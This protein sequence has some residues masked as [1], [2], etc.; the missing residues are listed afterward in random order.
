MTEHFDALNASDKIRDAYRDYLLTSNDFADA[1]VRE[2]F[3]RVLE[4]RFP[5]TKGPF[6]QA[7]PP[8]KKS[9]SLNELARDGVL[10]AEIVS[11]P[12]IIPNSD[13]PLYD[14]QVSAIKKISAG[15]NVVVATGTGSGKTEA[16]LLPIINSLLEERR[17]GTLSKPGVRAL[18]LYPMNAL[19]NDQLDR[20]RE[21]LANLPDITFGRYT[22]EVGNEDESSQVENYQRRYG[23]DPIPNEMLSRERMRDTPPHILLS[24]FTMLEYLLIRPVD[25]NFFDGDT[26]NHWRFIV[27]DEVH[28]YQG[29]KGGEIRMLLK[30]LRDRVVTSARDRITYIGTSATIGSLESDMPKLAEY[31]SLLFDETVEYSKS[32]DRCDIIRPQFEKQREYPVDVNL[33]ADQIADLHEAVVN[34]DP[35]ALTDLLDFHLAERGAHLSLPKRLG[36]LLARESTFQIILQSLKERPRPIDEIIKSFSGSETPR[37]TASQLI[38]LA[39]YAEAPGDSS[40]LLSARYHLLLRAL[41][42]M[43]YCY[44]QSHPE[45]QPRMSLEPHEHCR[46]CSQEEPSVMFEIGPCVQCGSTYLIGKV[47]NT[48]EGPRLGIAAPLGTDNVYLTLFDESNERDLEGDEDDDAFAVEAGIAGDSHDVR[49][50]CMKCGALDEGT[51]TCDHGNARR[52]VIHSKPKDSESPMRK[53]VVCSYQTR[54]NAIN[55]VQT[56]QDAPNSILA[57]AIYQQLPEAPDMSEAVGGGR[58]LL[59]FSDSRQDAAFFAPY[60]ERTYMRNVQRRLLL[61]ALREAD[62]VLR[63]EDLVGT[64]AR[65]SQRFH[66]L[67]DI[68]SDSSPEVEVR[69]WM[70]REALNLEG[71]LSLIG[72]GLIRIDSR[73]PAASIPT[74]LVESG[75]NPVESLHVLQVLLQIMREKGAID[76]PPTIDISDPIFAPRN[77]VS[78]MRKTSD[79]RILGWSP[80]AKRTNSRLDYLSRLQNEPEVSNKTRELLEAI[81]DEITPRTSAWHHLFKVDT[82]GNVP[83]LCLDY[84]MLD[85]SAT[86]V[87]EDVYECDTCRRVSLRNV[88]DICPQYRCT[89]RLR[90]GESKTG[91]RGQYEKLY[92][93]QLR[94]GMNVEEHTGQLSNTRASDVQQK[95]VE[96]YINTLSCSTTFEL[97]VDLGEIRAVLMKNVPP[98]AANYAQRAGRAGRRTSSTALVTTF[99]Q[100]RNHDLFYFAHPEEL[101]R[102]VVQAPQISIT[103]TLIIRRHIHSVALSAF[104]RQV[105]EEGGEWPRELNVGEFFYDKD[106]AGQT[107]AARFESWLRTHPQQLG[108][109]LKRIVDDQSTSSELGIQNWL[110][111]D[112]LYTDTNLN[113]KGWMRKAEIVIREHLADIDAL[114]REKEAEGRQLPT[115]SQKALA[116]ANTLRILQ[117]QANTIRGRKLIDYL[118]QRIVLPK[119]GFPVDVVSLDILSPNSTAGADIDLS[120]DLQMGILEF[121]PG[122][123]TVANKLLWEGNGLRIPPDKVLPEF[124]WRVCAK[125]GTFRTVNELDVGCDVCGSIESTPSV[126]AIIPSF[127]FLGKP[128][129]QKPG[130]SRPSRVG[131]LRSF[132]TEFTGQMPELEHVPIGKESV[133]VRVGKEA[134]VTVLNRGP[135]NAGFQICLTCGGAQPPSRSVRK[136][137]NN[138]PEKPHKRPGIRATEC[139]HRQ[140]R[141]VLG[142]QFRTDA[143]QIDLPG[144][145]TYEQGES[146]L[147]ALLAATEKL[148]IP[149]DDLKGTSRASRGGGSRSIVIYD[150]VP[151]GAG[152]SRAVREALD[153]LFSEAAAITRNCTCGEETSCYGCL[154]SY[155]NQHIHQELSRRR[156]NEVF[157]SLG[158]DTRI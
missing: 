122:S 57:S 63:F 81:W 61:D 119:Y 6:V 85:F 53:C 104:A 146:V 120:R 128:S 97:G 134:V 109:S 49:T 27:L 19:A 72:T 46:S 75:F 9:M 108:E 110:W 94:I 64:I 58:K 70:L 96:G 155:A 91:R 38:Y 133:G 39:K 145:V 34:N 156:A 18:L 50:L 144:L 20:L 17:A 150:A 121:A 78:R 148:D 124:D 130:D 152:Y 143:I 73:I 16:F 92:S 65:Q 51:P 13:R 28:T 112:D 151:G 82:K 11:H 45:S 59:C 142:H 101:V 26:G 29:A 125:C 147:A 44:A 132:F 23:K 129:N 88:R 141:R 14:H 55:R 48:D 158:L 47:N 56:G 105:V 103:N 52:K 15:R 77:F 83:S 84:K 35:A 4:Q 41:E 24:N 113:E 33:T 138:Q 71:R 154:R 5:L 69:K 66:V 136:R 22:G 98:T 126:K 43:F 79:G 86:N 114:I 62:E 32:D 42:G 117:K 67:S 137:T 111:V 36:D 139:T 21:L 54:G 93:Q 31:A 1:S 153:K 106:T 25:T 87:E 102:G 157:A 68:S 89:G 123:T 80:K 107:M 100:R 115:G 8:Y 90:R 37:T 74:A 60:L 30:R 40:P 2:E 140:V 116:I 99:A 118:A 149:R 135:R 95:F 12:T 7:T 131:S 76:I 10:S 3:N 127:G